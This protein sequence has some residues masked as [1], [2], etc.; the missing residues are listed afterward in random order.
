MA[1]CRRFHLPTIMVLWLACNGVADG[2]NTMCPVSCASRTSDRGKRRISCF[3]GCATDQIP[4]EKIDSKVEVLEILIS[5]EKRHWLTVA[6]VFQ[7]F[8]FLEELYIRNSSIS[9]ISM[10]AFWGVPSLK[11]LNLSLNNISNVLDHNFRGLLNLVELNLDDNRI[12]SLQSGVF[13]H[14]TELRILSLQRN[15]LK[16]LVP[17]TFLKLTKLHVLK[18]S[19][20]KFEDLNPEAFKEIPELRMFECRNCSL[21]RINTQIYHLL[22][23]LTLLDLGDNG[24]QFLSN[25]E[26]QDLRRLHSLKLDGNLLSVVLE[27]IF[28]NQQQLKFLTLARNRIV[29]ITDYALKNL[30]SLED[31]DISYNKL[32]KLEAIVFTHITKTLKRIVLSGNNLNLDLI[33]MVIEILHSLTDIELAQMKL[34][35]IP[36]HF[37]PARIRKLDISRNNFSEITRSVIPKQ[38]VYLNISK[39][40]IK[41]FNEATLATLEGIKTVDVTGNPWN[42][43]LCDISAVVLRAN[44]SVLFKQSV[45]S[46]PSIMRG[47]KLISLNIH[48]LPGCSTSGESDNG[49]S[50]WLSIVYMTAVAFSVPLIAVVVYACIKRRNQQPLAVDDTTKRTTELEGYGMELATAVFIKEQISFQFPLNLMESKMSVSTIDDVKKQNGKDLLSN[51]RAAGL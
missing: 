36:E 6:P 47:K 32:N 16:E 2:T 17:K 38:L 40:R 41:G 46:S 51:G 42:C 50:G 45:C 26:F 21:R 5:G 27:N 12:V 37:F 44:K 18:I 10:H 34:E 3:A 1:Y 24:I 31:L 8:K 49:G 7:H 25:D 15:L 43:N 23:Y 28:I 14:L 48:H 30:T 19:G 4:I 20:N 39:N 33:Y 22:P 13:K 9:Q 29:K 11:V 35:V